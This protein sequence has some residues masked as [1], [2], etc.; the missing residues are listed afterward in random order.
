MKPLPA[1]DGCHQ[2]NLSTEFGGG[3]VYTRSCVEAL[4]QLGIK[5]R[6]YIHPQATFWRSLI[7]DMAECVP[8]PELGELTAALPAE[9][10]WVL[11][12]GALPI[13]VTLRL[14]Q[15]HYMTA[16]SHMPRYLRDSSAYRVYDTVFGVSRYVVDGLQAASVPVYPEPLLGVAAPA[17]GRSASL[18]PIRQRSRYQWDQRKGRDRMLGWL[19]RLRP[20]WGEAPVYEKRPGLTLGI[21]SRITTIKQFPQLF[22]AIVPALL[23]RPEVNI[24]I[25]G[26][27]GYASVRDLQRVLRP[28]GTRVRWWGHQ[29]DVVR[30]YQGLDYLMSGLPEKEALGLNLIEAQAMGVPVL[31]V[32]APPFT[33]TVIHGETGWLYTD[34]RIDGGASFGAMLDALRSQQWP[35]LQPEKSS[36]FAVFTMAAFVERWRGVLQHLPAWVMH[37]ECHVVD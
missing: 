27:G 2:V 9:G 14:G 22:A 5:T 20:N 11:C 34:P 31:A 13:E 35:H 28:L 16:I 3:E 26:S 17:A 36:Q 15:R 24:E 6:L 8:I 33:E 12:H 30:V 7:G 29:S 32:Q 19:A 10:A 37:K 25:F 1:L 18:A 21:V 23:A 4:A